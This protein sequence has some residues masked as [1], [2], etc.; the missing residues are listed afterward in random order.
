VHRVTPDRDRH[1]LRG[2]PIVL[3]SLA[4]AAFAVVPASAPPAGEPLAA[5]AAGVADPGTAAGRVP[6]GAQNI[7]F[8]PVGF[9]S[10]AAVPVA[11]PEQPPVTT[12]A[13]PGTAAAAAIEFALAQRGLPYVWGGDGPQQGEEGFDC[14]GLTTAA[15]AHAGV[16]L[17]RTA[18]TQY[19][20][21]PHVPAGAGLLPGDLVFY[22]VPER[23]HHVG[24]YLGDGMMVNA[25]RR[26]KPV[27]IA[28]VRY[29]GDTYLGATRPA[30]GIDASA[31]GLLT[32]PQ[33]PVPV[34]A[35]PSPTAPPAPEEF[36]A[37][38]VPEEELVRIAA[39]PDPAPPGPG[40][41]GPATTP[42]PL[43]GPGLAPATTPPVPVPPV[44]PGVSSP[45]PTPP[46][47]TPSAGLPTTPP[48]TTPPP[49][50]RPP[51]TTPPPATTTP[52][53]T[54]PPT[55]TPPTTTPPPT[56]PPPPPEPTAEAAPAAP[57]P[58]TL[59]LPGGSLALA[60][61]EEGADGLPVAPSSPGTGGLRFAEAEGAEPAR[62][63]VALHPDAPA[64]ADGA[65][66]TWR[67]AG[68]PITLT[69]RSVRTV[70]APEAAEAAAARGG[71][72]RLVLVRTDPATGATL[73]VVAE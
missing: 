25:P 63:V 22:G 14:S 71:S 56:T 70:P 10:P 57:R 64:I 54:T 58:E 4:A 9:R 53:T 69:V 42:A 13:L 8:D 47:T 50:T 28:R 26:G 30:A 6:D 67:G 48:V 41:A 3:V 23:V 60:R 39:A 21:G 15:Y 37:P 59:G 16:A 45:T 65:T 32:T 38:A 43:Q 1:L 36:P 7:R 73:L 72:T 46:A 17:P 20:R 52:P 44:T 34:P 5:A 55:T 68:G 2:S 33:L 29:P 12:T 31:E 11:L 18:H 40:P 49:T 62:A 51:A 27:Q 19:H 61:A 66:I 24:L 35:R